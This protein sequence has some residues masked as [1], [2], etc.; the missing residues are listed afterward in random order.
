MLQQDFVIMIGKVLTLSLMTFS[1]VGVN[2]LLFYFEFLSVIFLRDKFQIINAA[3]RLYA[4]L[5]E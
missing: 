1:S 4:F 2:D 3:Y 5:K